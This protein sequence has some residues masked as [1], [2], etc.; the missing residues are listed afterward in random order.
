MNMKPP[1]SEPVEVSWKVENPAVTIPVGS[2]FYF[3]FHRHGSVGEDAT[4]EI[5]DEDIVEHMKTDVHYKHPERMK[6]GWTGGDAELGKWY[7]KAIKQG[8]AKIVVQE[9][10]RFEVEDTYVVDVT[11]TE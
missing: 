2:I 1:N 4:F 6:P 3:N 8:N 10:F 11:V 7:F 9:L 5:V